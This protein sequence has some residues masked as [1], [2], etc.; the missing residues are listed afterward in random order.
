MGFPSNGEHKAAAKHARSRSRARELEG[1]PAWL[2]K[3]RMHGIVIL[4]GWSRLHPENGHSEFDC[5]CLQ[6]FEGD[7]AAL[8]VNLFLDFPP[9]RL[10][11]DCVQE[12]V[13]GERQGQRLPA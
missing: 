10:V 12:F 7:G 8:F 2:S 6:D 5:K 4:S 1:A 13:S 11:P 3:P 9:N